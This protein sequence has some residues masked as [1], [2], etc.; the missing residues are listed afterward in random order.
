MA[1]ESKPNFRGW[2]SGFFKVT[3]IV[4]RSKLRGPGQESIK[5][6][7]TPSQGSYFFQRSTE[8]V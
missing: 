2:L 6:L 5:S 7:K 1:F 3:V 8:V 4:P